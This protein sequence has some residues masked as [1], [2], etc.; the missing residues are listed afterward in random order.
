MKQ[1]IDV[2]AHYFPP[3][4]IALLKKY[5]IEYLDGAAKPEWSIDRQLKYMEELNIS[6]AYL[7]LSSPHIHMGNVQE[8]IETARLCN[9][10]GANL[11]STYDKKIKIMASL[12]L[13]EIDASV[14]EIR[15]CRDTLHVAGFAMLTHSSGIYLGD[16]YLDP[17]MEE[18]N[19][20]PTVVV[21]HPTHP[22]SI[23]NGVNVGIPDAMLEY[24][25]DTTRAATNMILNK[26]TRRYKNIKW[27]IPHGGAFLS[28][29]SDRLDTLFKV[30]NFDSK[31][32]VREALSEFYYDLA[33]MAMPKQYDL[34]KTITDETHLLYG[35][36][37]PFTPNKLCVKLAE[38]MDE[39]LG[40]KAQKIYINNAIKL[41]E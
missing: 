38:N 34:L 23:P 12:P 32:D 17:I 4:Y 25:F 33:G 14:E 27:I 35:S 18:L 1:R 36:D 28:I 24:F 39:K 29:A 7:S 10:Y 9:E 21:I 8:A 3:A 41:F 11:T 5:H 19:K 20:S 15:Y 37:M 2:H 22:V 30:M 6:T 40:E 31:I 13:P 26:I 16:S